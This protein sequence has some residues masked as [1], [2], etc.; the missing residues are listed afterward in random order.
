[1][2]SF[3][4]GVYFK[5][6]EDFSDDLPDFNSEKS[7]AEAYRGQRASLAEDRRMERVLRFKLGLHELQVTAEKDPVLEAANRRHDASSNP[8]IRLAV[9][10]LRNEPVNIQQQI[11]EYSMVVARYAE[12]QSAQDD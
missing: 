6:T 5:T 3:V 11:A 9:S 10:N 7:A 2:L 8:W 4:Q 12:T 1:M